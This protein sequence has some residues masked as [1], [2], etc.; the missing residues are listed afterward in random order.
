M[1]YYST[2]GKSERVNFKEA[3]I[4]GLAP[5]GG[6]FFPEQIPL[7]NKDFFSKLKKMSVS[8]IGHAILKPYV[9]DCLKDKDLFDIVSQA[10]DFSIPLKKINKNQFVLE[11]FHGNTLAFKDVGAR[12]M[13]RCL[14]HF[15]KGENRE[16][17]VL[18]ATSGDTGGA[19]ADGFYGVEGVNVVILFPSG[20]VSE[21]QE[22]QMAA[23]G[24]NI[25]A[26]EIEGDFDDCQ[27]LV[28]QAFS[29]L[30]LRKKLFLTSANSINVARWIPQQLFYFM[31][32][33]QW[34]ETAEVPVISVPSGN[35]GNICAGL[36]AKKSGLPIKKFIAACNENDVI[37]R[38][39]KSG[40]Y[41]IKSTIHT[42]SNA[43]DVGSPSN[44]VRILELYGN[45][46]EAL[47]YDLVA[48][49]YD[50]EQTRKKML[51]TFV[52]SNYLLDPHG[53]VG[54]LALQEYQHQYPSSF[55]IFTATAHPIKFF[56]TVEKIVGI[57]Q[58]L[59]LFIS[60]L[61]EKESHSLKMSSD[62]SS[63]SSYLTQKF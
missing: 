48:Y 4:A 39:F 15:I 49:R 12:F 60:T 31:A 18:V 61:L 47:N 19:V 56:D 8:E 13:S 25:H 29:D 2:N 43:M 16:M 10:F 27:N 24:G 58:D 28:K 63:L 52:E 42:L 51:D 5:D 55:G 41:D 62:Y 59:P 38:F 57:K 45:N 36:L 3:T 9:G 1:K 30:D 26:I 32:W 46:I 21:V 44:F 33:S 54:L 7:H 40:K 23:M 20:K 50:D 11:L 6:L 53:A 14:G 37:P 17:T 34:S 22:K 35:F